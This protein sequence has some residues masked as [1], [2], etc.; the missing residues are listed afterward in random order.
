M[1]DILIIA[2]QRAL[3]QKTEKIID[4]EGL[5]RIDIFWGQSTTRVLKFVSEE[6]SGTRFRTH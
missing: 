3:V 2:T 6:L 5:D 4:D 1:K